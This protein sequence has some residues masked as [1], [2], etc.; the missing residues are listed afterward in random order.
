MIVTLPLRNDSKSQ[1]FNFV[2]SYRPSNCCMTISIIIVN[3]NVKHFLEHCLYSVQK[4]C[5]RIRAEVIVVDNDSKDGSV[6]YLRPQFPEVNFFECKKNLGFARANNLGLKM[7]KGKYILFLNPDTLLP[8]DS[9]E[10]CIKFLDADEKIG[11]AGVRMIDGSGNFLRES[12]R[13]FP[14]PLTSLYKL[15]GLYAL[16]PK[17]PIFSKYHLGHLSEHKNHEVDVLSGAFMIARKTVLDKTGGFDKTF[18]MYGEDIDLSFRIQKQGYRNFYFAETTIIHFKGESTS[19]GSLNYVRMFYQAMEIFVK[20]HYGGVRKSV[21]IFLLQ[22]GIWLHATLKILISFIKK[23]SL[24]V[25]DLFFFLSSF[26]L[27][28]FFWGDF[29]KPETEYNSRLLGASFVIF[30]LLYLSVAWIWGL[31]DKTGYRTKNVAYASVFAII[32]LLAV[33]SLFPEQYRFSRGIVLLGSITGFFMLMIFRFFLVESGVIKTS[34][35]KAEHFA[36][37][38][39]GNENEYESVLKIL[40]Q[41]D[42]DQTI[43]ALAKDVADLE[44]LQKQ[45]GSQKIILCTESLGY[46]N[47]INAIDNLPKN[48]RYRFFNNTSKTI[49]SSHCKDESG[50]TESFSKKYKLNDPFYRRIKRLFDIAASLLFLISFPLHVFFVKN[51]IGLLS[52]I[53]KVLFGKK[54]WVGYTTSSVELKPLKQSVLFLN[55]VQTSKNENLKQPNNRLDEWYA[56]EYSLRIDFSRLVSFYRYLGT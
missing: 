15:S 48:L 43:I 30:S 42:E 6:E 49:I 19:K 25:F 54:T 38:V 21:F 39:A 27:A 22:T 5:E 2:E 50:A 24:P 41:N 11:A 37:L 20:K 56:R 26:W 14:G 13:S 28:K 35:K 33:Y 1:S 46:K 17:S 23:I 34:D 16:F 3:Y 31:Y 7:S 40:K 10:K 29:V 53:I 4:A 32:G 47:S 51:P 18:F 8:E 12:K 9:L 36:G 45:T 44:L 55:G 52:N